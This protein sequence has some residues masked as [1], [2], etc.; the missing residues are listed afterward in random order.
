MAEAEYDVDEGEWVDVAEGPSAEAPFAGVDTKVLRRL[1][2]VLD[3]QG[4]NNEGGAG[5]L[6]AL[7]PSDPE[8]AKLQRMLLDELGM[9]PAAALEQLR[10]WQSAHKDMEKE[11]QKQREKKKQGLM[12]QE[13]IWRCSAVCGRANKPYIACWV[14]PYI[15]GY[16]PVAM[17][18]Q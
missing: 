13:P 2:V 12:T 16:Q 14:A 9:S 11:L 10:K 8:L 3:D 15:V 6:A 5:Q 4:L 7:D 18:E 1:Q 17:A